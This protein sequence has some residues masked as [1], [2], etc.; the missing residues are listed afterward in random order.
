MLYGLVKRLVPIM[1]VAFL[2]CMFVLLLAAKL[3]FGAYSYGPF[4]ILDEYTHLTPGN[5]PP[6]FHRGCTYEYVPPYNYQEYFYCVVALNDNPHFER[7]AYSGNEDE[8]TSIHFTVRDNAVT[9]GHLL[10]RFGYP[11]TFREYNYKRGHARHWNWG[12][13][14]GLTAYS[15][16]LNVNT[17]DPFHPLRTI[18]F[19]YDTSYILSDMVIQ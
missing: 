12:G 11:D 9:Y 16:I 15:Q 5:E 2:I 17:D 14:G 6:D 10:L 3:G 1:V 13:Y 7:M 8:I 19:S 18:Y 4:V